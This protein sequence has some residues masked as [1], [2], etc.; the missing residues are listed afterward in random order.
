MRIQVKW[1]KDYNGEY[2]WMCRY[3]NIV[4]KSS[5]HPKRC[6][7]GLI[8]KLKANEVDTSKISNV[9]DVVDPA[10]KGTYNEYKKS[11]YNGTMLARY[12]YRK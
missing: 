3:G 4:S 10:M 11:N 5:I 1:T 7:D 8:K 6:F 2:I 9:I 12:L